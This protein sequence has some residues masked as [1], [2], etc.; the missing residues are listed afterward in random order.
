MHTLETGQKVKHFMRA[1]IVE[2]SKIERDRLAL[3][4]G[5]IEGLQLVGQTGN[6]K[7]AA[8]SILR[9]RPD[10]VFVGTKIFDYNGLDMPCPA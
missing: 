4:L 10:V 1:F 6:V 7:S 2:N 8:E 5:D 9:Q 3:L